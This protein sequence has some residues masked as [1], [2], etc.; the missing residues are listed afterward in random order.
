MRSY[1]DIADWYDGVVETGT[2]HRE[3]VLP[4]LLELAGD[5]SGQR[6]LDVACGQGLATRELA[7]R[8]AIVTGVDVSRR[9]LE[10]ARQREIEEPL[11]IAY[12]EGDA[13][14]L[15]GLAD[16]AF[17]GATCCMALWLP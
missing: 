10:R 1:D 14:T 2:F 12:Q 13:E 9:L 16:G 8:G 3:H 7:R 5:V 11:G 15:H 17:D 6:V 4:A